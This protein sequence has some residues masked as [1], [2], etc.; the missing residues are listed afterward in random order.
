LVKKQKPTLKTASVTKIPFKNN[1]FDVVISHETLDHMLISDAKNAIEEIKRVC[2][3]GGYIYVSF[4]STQDSE[5]GRG[6]EVD[7]NTFVLEKGYEKGL[8]QHY[9]DLEEILKLLKNL[10][11]FDITLINEKF[12]SSYTIDK[13]FL[14]SSQSFKQYF[15]LNESIDIDNK[16]S[17]WHI[18]AENI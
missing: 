14:Q 12:P 6:M 16:N 13:A 18:I 17:R 8:I 10:K 1:Y 5:F 15:D 3:P 4:R 7:S 11:I 9:F 2:S